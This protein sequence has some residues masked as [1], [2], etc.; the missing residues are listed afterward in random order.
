MTNEQIPPGFIKVVVK[1]M[2]KEP[3]IVSEAEALDL[4]RQNLLVTDNAQVRKL[5]EK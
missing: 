2:P 4:K 1:M 3:I 5:E